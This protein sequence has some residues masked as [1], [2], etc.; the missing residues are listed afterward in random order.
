MDMSRLKDDLRRRCL[1]RTTSQRA[2]LI[3]RRRQV[4]GSVTESHAAAL[5]AEL[6]NT[7]DQRTHACVSRTTAWTE[8]DEARLQ[9]ELGNEAYLELMAA[10]EESLLLEL[11]A[12]VA[13]LEDTASVEDEPAVR[14][15]EAMLAAEECQLLQEAER[16][17]VSDGAAGSV[18]CPICWQAPLLLDASGFVTCSA[19][20]GVHLDART[21]P[22]EPLELLRAR[23]DQLHNEHRRTCSAVAGARIPTLIERPT[24]GQLAFACPTCGVCTRIV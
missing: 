18:L 14:E 15:Y 16:A 12:D 21:A 4:H 20:C 7:Y 24:L 11:E 19:S 8:A 1:A 23:L 2:A 9:F 10:T 3:A 17:P 5:G 6:M 13:T 22:S